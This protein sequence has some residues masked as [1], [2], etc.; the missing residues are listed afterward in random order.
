MQRKTILSALAAASAASFAA[1][2]APAGAAV[3]SASI[4][5][6]TATLNLDAARRQRDGVG[7]RGPARAW[8]ATG[9]GL[10]SASDWDSVTPGDQTVPADG[11]FTCGR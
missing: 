1:T 7:V 9:G 10:N 4:S 5:G 3:S 2:A 8:P 11:T 6:T